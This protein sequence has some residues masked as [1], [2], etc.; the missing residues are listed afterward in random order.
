MTKEDWVE[1][2]LTNKHRIATLIKNFT[3]VAAKNR[4]LQAVKRKDITGAYDE[5]CNAWTA[6]P[7]GENKEPWVTHLDAW[8]IM[9][10]LYTH[11]QI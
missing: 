5:I 7:S 10:E 8:F 1:I 11:Y 4:F 6:A 3:G 9:D 2:L